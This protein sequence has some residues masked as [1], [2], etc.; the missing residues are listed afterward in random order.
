ML[1][2]GVLLTKIAIGD[3]LLQRLFHNAMSHLTRLAQP[4]W[5]ASAFATPADFAVVELWLASDWRAAAARARCTA[6][7][8]NTP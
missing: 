1:P 2:P 6:D 5:T 7:G 8:G 4:Q 3:A